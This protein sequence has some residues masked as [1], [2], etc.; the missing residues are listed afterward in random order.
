M[1]VGFAD[2][3]SRVWLLRHVCSRHDAALDHEYVAVQLAA[4]H[5]FSKELGRLL[6]AFVVGAAF[7]VHPEFVVIEASLGAR[8]HLE[9]GAL[10]CRLA[11]QLG[12]LAQL[13]PEEVVRLDALNAAE[14]AAAKREGRS[15]LVG[16]PAEA[17]APAALAQ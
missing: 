5:L 16:P 4:A 8:H 6:I 14:V 9:H 3:G 15:W 2:F 1:G 13:P 17:A 11:A 7:F 10:A 12:A